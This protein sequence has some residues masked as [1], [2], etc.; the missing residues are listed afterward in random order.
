MCVCVC[1]CV[2]VCLK[3]KSSANDFNFVLKVVFFVFI[4]VS[5]IRVLFRKARSILLF[6]SCFF[7]KGFF[8][9]T[10]VKLYSITHPATIFILS[11][12]LW[13]GV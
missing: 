4:Y 9:V 10:V 3:R 11:D 5:A 7:S 13:L 2:C 8:K 1:V 12:R 6:Q